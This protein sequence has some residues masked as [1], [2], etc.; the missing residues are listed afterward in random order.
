MA[1]PGAVID[2]VGA[3]AGAHQLLK[4]VGLL[5]GAL[6]RTEASER[7]GAVAI[8]NSLQAGSR[9]VERF[10]P[11][12]RPEMRPWIGGIDR[13]VRVL[14]HAFLADQRLREAMRV[15]HIVE[16]E[17]PLH[18]QP[19]LVGRPVRA[20]DMNELVVLDMIGELTADAAIRTNAVHL[21]IGKL[22]P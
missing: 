16:A 18:A 13:V 12:R 7:A 20:A 19:V 6:G 8:A 2:I 21:A 22:G 14:A 3:E 10:L 1:E 4:K 5:V 15:V 17:A 11:G 9:A